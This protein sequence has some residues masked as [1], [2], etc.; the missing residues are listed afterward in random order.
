MYVVDRRKTPGQSRRRQIRSVRD[1]K[2]NR[3][4]I[5]RQRGQ[6]VGYRPITE[7]LPGR[8]VEAFRRLGAGIGD[9]SLGLFDERLKARRLRGKWKMFMIH[10][11]T[12][13]SCWLA[14]ADRSAHQNH[15]RGVALNCCFVS[16]RVSLSVK[17]GGEVGGDRPKV[18]LDFA[19]LPGRGPVRRAIA[20]T[21]RGLKLAGR[22]LHRFSHF[23][24]TVRR[25]IVRRRCCECSQAAWYEANVR[26]MS[27]RRCS[28]I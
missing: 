13:S 3:G 6:I 9:E 14:R 10:V 17:L 26:E 25:E 1:E 28:S 16:Q 27:D 12:P 2:G 24:E 8:L 15:A 5:C 23:R 20:T 4:R 22:D 18:D 19:S 11:T 21:N 7:V